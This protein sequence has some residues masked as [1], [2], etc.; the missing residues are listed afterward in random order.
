MKLRKN[1][2]TQRKSQPRK[3]HQEEVLSVATVSKS[4]RKCEDTDKRHAFLKIPQQTN[5]TKPRH[6]PLF[7]QRTRGHARGHSR[8]RSLNQR[9]DGQATP[10]EA[11]ARTG[12]EHAR[13]ERRRARAL[14]S[15]T[16]PHRR[17][18]RRARSLE[19]TRHIT[20]APQLQSSALAPR[21]SARA[22]RRNVLIHTVA[23]GHGARRVPAAA[24]LSVWSSDTAHR[25]PRPASPRPSA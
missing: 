22:Q 6:I 5:S 4:E 18:H 17:S 8:A 9:Q 24:S 19:C 7:P 20:S 12:A 25:P 11:G 2:R 15:S 16:A 13:R 21:A 3:R 1:F 23:G 10:A 14:T